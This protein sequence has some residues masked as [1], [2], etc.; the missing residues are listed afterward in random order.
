MTEKKIKVVG[1]YIIKPKEGSAF[2]LRGKEGKLLAK[3]GDRVLVEIENKEYSLPKT[4]I[5]YI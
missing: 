1:V 5:E 3:K 4:V 2:S